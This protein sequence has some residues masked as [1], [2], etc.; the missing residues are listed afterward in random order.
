MWEND[1]RHRDGVLFRFRRYMPKTE[2]QIMIGDIDGDCKITISD[3]TTLQRY[4]AEFINSDG[5]AIIDEINEEMLKVADVSCDGA[6]SIADVTIIQ[7]YL[8]E[9]PVDEGIGKPLTKI[10]SI[11]LSQTS[12]SLII[13]QSQTLT[14]DIAPSDAYFKT[15]QWSSSDIS[16]ATVDQNGNIRAVGHG[17]VRVHAQKGGKDA[18]IMVNVN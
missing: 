8:A 4:L 10:S 18:C 6:V 1:I 16:V 11:T 2:A 7:R 13:G 9:F 17:S 3:V 12:M 14:A 5:S 15:V